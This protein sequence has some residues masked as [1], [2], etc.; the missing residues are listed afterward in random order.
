GWGVTI[1]YQSRSVHVESM[2]DFISLSLDCLGR[3][4][5]SAGALAP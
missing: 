4:S 1:W 3:V 5:I 2:V